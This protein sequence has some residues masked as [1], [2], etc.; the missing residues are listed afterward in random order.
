MP[1]TVAQFL[2][3]RAPESLRRSLS[4]GGIPTGVDS[5][6]L[7]D[8]TALRF[9]N[10]PSLVLQQLYCRRSETIVELGANVGYFTVRGALAAPKARYIAVEPHPN[11]VATC[12]SHL[13]LNGVA[14][15]E[16]VAAAAVPE[17]G[18]ESLEMHVPSDQLATP[19]VAFL[20]HGSELPRDM[21]QEIGATIEVAA[22]DVRTLV[23]GADLI[24]LDVEGQEH[25]LLGA[26]VDLL[27]ERRPH[28]VVE[29]LRGTPK[30][31]AL[32]SDLCV[33][34]GYHCYVPVETG[35]VELE[36]A[37]IATVNLQSGYGT[38]D[39]ILSIDATLPSRT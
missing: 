4:H 23:S 6:G 27:A 22:V 39:V 30:L 36:S 35:L 14:S 19:T 8:E 10:T 5:F 9:T 26:I 17:R 3:K 21:A 32:L 7:S 24:K 29:M 25:L 34:V 13:E 16:L 2:R 12:K 15:V 1:V 28:V 20:P 37:D 31:R 33:G 18:P 11:S 38:N